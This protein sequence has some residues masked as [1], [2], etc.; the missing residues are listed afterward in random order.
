MTI[1]AI[2][3]IVAIHE[4]V[5]EIVVAEVV[6]ALEEEEYKIV[7]V[8]AEIKIGDR[9]LVDHQDLQVHHHLQVLVIV[10]DLVVQDVL[11]LAVV[12]EVH[13]DVGREQ[14]PDIMYLYPKLPSIFLKAVSTN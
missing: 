8:E 14:H 11:V 13:P 6:V 9:D 1:D 10:K 4:I 7:N 5:I 2:E 12:L 3:M